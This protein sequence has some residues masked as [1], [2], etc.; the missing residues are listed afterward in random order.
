MARG[1]S[2][3]SG[4]IADVPRIL[5]QPGGGKSCGACCGM[6][7]HREADERELRARLEARTRAFRE[8]CDVREPETLRAFR[9][10]WEDA[11]EDKLLGEL[12]SC[13][14]LGMLDDGE[15]DRVGC[16]VHPLQNGG[17]DGRDCGVYDRHTCE[18]YLC[19]AHSVMTREE[20]WLV[21]AA[22]RDSY[23][24]GLVVTD[25]RYVRELFALAA[26]RNGAMPTG[27]A[28]GREGVL[29]AARAYFELKRD[30]PWRAPDGVFGQVVP[31]EGL[32][33]PRRPGPSEQVSVEEDE[34][35]SALRCLGTQVEDVAGLEAARA[36]V[37][38]RVEAFAKAVS[39]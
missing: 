1:E 2:A 30:W 7:N 4:G 38:A 8:R 11:P 26:R 33:T 3:W 22:T 12:P 15:T 29:E 21:L 19:A 25:V 32:E 16:M 6:Y 23:V 34:Y 35:E 37:A 36:R 24:Y 13:P 5:C 17:V 28:L 39:A 31:G 10:E 27:K 9:A 14:F 20:R 18:D